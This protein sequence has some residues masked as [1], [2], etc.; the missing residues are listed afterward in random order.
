MEAEAASAARDL[1]AQ[2]RALRT[3]FD[4]FYDVDVVDGRPIA[5]MPGE[6][7]L[8]IED[9]AGLAD[10]L[11]GLVPPLPLRDQLS[12]SLAIPEAR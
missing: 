3:E 9:V 4:N 8:L 2:V 1:I 11:A 6:I 10:R 12:A 7:A 5:N